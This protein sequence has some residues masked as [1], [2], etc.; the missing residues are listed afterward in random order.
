MSSAAFN[1]YLYLLDPNGKIIAFDDDSA[2]GTDARIPSSGGT[3]SLPLS[4]SYTVIA[5]KTGSSFQAESPQNGNYVLSIGSPT[6]AS[7]TVSG[8]VI[9]SNEIGLTRASVTFT[10]SQGDARTVL[11]GKGGRFRFS[12]VV[13]GETYIFSVSARRHTFTPQIITVNGDITDLD[14]SA[15]Q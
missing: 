4:G 14:F 3:I 9:L 6:A 2:G 8:R 13:V 1:T 12:D 15:V 11:T 5:T 7:A 10:D